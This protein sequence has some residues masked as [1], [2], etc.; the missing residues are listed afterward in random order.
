MPAARAI[1]IGVAETTFGRTFAGLP[2]VSADV[3]NVTALLD[4]RGF[5]VARL[6]D[7]TADRAVNRLQAFVDNLAADDLGVVYLAGHGF[8]ALDDDG[9]EDDGLEECFVC[10]DTAIRD[11]TFRALWARA[12]DGSRLVIVVDACHSESLAV[13]LAPPDPDRRIETRPLPPDLPPSLLILSACAD[14]DTAGEGK[15]GGIVTEEMLGVLADKPQIVYRDLWPR[16]AGRVRNRNRHVG[17][18][19]YKAPDDGLIDLPAFRPPA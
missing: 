8:Q 1:V 14:S 16:V 9:D 5:A 12:A 13:G 2:G 17:R 18:P 3:D 4:D 15:G 11:D 10:A 6:D 19:Y 7:P